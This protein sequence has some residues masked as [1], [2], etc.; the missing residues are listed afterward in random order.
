LNDIRFGK[1]NDNFLA[2]IKGLSRN[3]SYEDGGEPIK[4]FSTNKE[5]YTCN[6]NK[7]HDIDGMILEYKAKEWS[8]AI[9]N[10]NSNHELS[11]DDLIKWLDKSTLSESTLY[12]KI[13]A[14]VLHI[15]NDKENKKLVN[16]SEGKIVGFRCGKTTYREDVP[17]NILSNSLIPI[18]KF[19]D[20]EEEVEIKKKRWQKKNNDG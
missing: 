14:E 19:K 13:G 12:L 9:D 1:I 6:M 2:Y 18:V 17:D 15:W 16:G 3:I 11:H 20:I 10:K 5:V 8:V 7:L 4:L